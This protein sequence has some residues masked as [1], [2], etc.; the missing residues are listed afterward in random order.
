MAIGAD[1]RS[2]IDTMQ[3][4]VCTSDVMAK[5]MAEKSPLIDEPLSRVNV[6]FMPKK[7]VKPDILKGELR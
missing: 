2:H 4:S 1:I 7:N 3:G 6:L 5:I